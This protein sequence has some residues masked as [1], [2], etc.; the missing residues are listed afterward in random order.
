[1]KKK[2]KTINQDIIIYVLPVTINELKLKDPM[3]TRLK[4]TKAQRY[5]NKLCS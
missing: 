4:L 5:I 3:K 1:M 2:K